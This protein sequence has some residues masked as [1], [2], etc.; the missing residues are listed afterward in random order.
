LLTDRARWWGGDDAQHYLTVARGHA[1]PLPDDMDAL[2]CSAS[3]VRT[4]LRSSRGGTTPLVPCHNDLLAANWIW[5]ARDTDCSGEATKEGTTA[6]GR[7]WLVDFEYGALGD[8]F[9]DLANFS[10]N[11]ELTDAQDAE[12][13]DC[14][15]G[16]GAWRPA[17]LARLKLYKVVS[18]LREGLWAFVQWGVSTTCSADFYVEYGHRHLRRFAQYAATTQFDTWLV[19]A[20]GDDER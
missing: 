14:Y 18:D 6:D 3:R 13:L 7:L 8:P 10:V 9:F 19:A 15:V 20:A 12:L 16:V 4:A 2:M 11:C 1:A 17:Q 5:G